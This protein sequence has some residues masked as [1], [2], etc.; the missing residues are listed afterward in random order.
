MGL[1]QEKFHHHGLGCL[2]EQYITDNHIG[3]WGIGWLRAGKGIIII[4]YSLLV[5]GLELLELNCL[6]LF[7]QG[8]ARVRAFFQPVLD[9]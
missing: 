6:S 5:F 4:F 8:V 9:Q 7:G 1:G 3:F 2:L